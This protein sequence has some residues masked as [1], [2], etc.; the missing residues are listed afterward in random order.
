MLRGNGGRIPPM[1][2]PCKARS[3]SRDA[4]SQGEVAGT[5]SVCLAKSSVPRRIPV[6]V[7]FDKRNL[8][9]RR[10]P[11]FRYAAICAIDDATANC[12][13]VR[14]LAKCEKNNDCDYAIHGDT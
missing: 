8:M 3:Q 10:N 1:K 6:I 11:R 14:A 12:G 5:V 9:N 2:S 7:D 13:G 4:R